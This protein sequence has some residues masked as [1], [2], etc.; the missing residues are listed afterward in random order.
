MSTQIQA[1]DKTYVKMRWKEDYVTVGLNRKLFGIVSAGIHRGG[2]MRAAGVAGGLN[3]YLDPDPTFGD[4]VIA[5]SD[6]ANWYQTTVRLDGIIGPLDLSG[7]ASSTIVVGVF[8]DYAQGSE[9]DAEIRAYTQA[10]WDGL[11]ANE[12]ASV[13]VCGKVV[14]P[15]SGD[16]EADD[17]YPEYRTEAWMSRALG[18]LPWKAVVQNGGFE[19]GW[20]WW[21]PSLVSAV[22]IDTAEKVDGLRSLKMTSAFGTPRTCYQSMRYP[23]QPDQKVRLCASMKVSGSLPTGAYGVGIRWLD[24]SLATVDEDT[25]LHVDDSDTNWHEYETVVKVPSGVTFLD[26]KLV[27]SQALAGAA[28]DVWYDNVQVYVERLQMNVEQEL[29]DGPNVDLMSRRLVLADLDEL[30]SGAAD[31]DKERFVVT[32]ADGE[33]TFAYEGDTTSNPNPAL[34]SESTKQLNFGSSSAR[35][36]TMFADTLNLSVVAGKGVGTPLVPDADVT[37]YLGDSSYRWG[38]LYTMR[39]VVAGDDTNPPIAWI[40]NTDGGPNE[41][42]WGW[43]AKA[44]TKELYLA[45]YTS[46]SAGGYRATA[47]SIMRGTGTTLAQ[48][49]A[50]THFIPIVGDTYDLGSSSFEW[51]DLYV[52]GVAY[53]DSLVVQIDKGLAV[54]KATTA[55]TNPD[56]TYRI[57]TICWDAS[58][59]YVKVEDGASAWKYINF[60][61]TV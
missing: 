41:K 37:H 51:K 50:G 28:R 17:L 1:I 30:I 22:T 27:C 7:F 24:S 56:T 47:L 42:V 31:A 13:A 53:I 18:Q 15:A 4:T 8:V 39:A 60:D 58:K 3:L 21:E 5:F 25:C 59:L 16:L 43:C 32:V 55:P 20:D 52:G 33:V 38:N 49:M 44:N 19:A 35:W 9:T 12:K 48:I 54:A 10:E 46:K 34:I 23:V 11:G 45:T 36:K 29:R 61:G 26:V 14:V 40:E 57:G 6:Q 2:I